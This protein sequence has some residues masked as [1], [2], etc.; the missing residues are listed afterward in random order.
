VSWENPSQLT[1]EGFSEP[2]A[3]TFQSPHLEE[4]NHP[5]RGV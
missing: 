3:Q 4:N 2:T 1:L 5:R